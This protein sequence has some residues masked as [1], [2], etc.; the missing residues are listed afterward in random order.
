MSHV[1]VRLLSILFSNFSVHSVSCVRRPYSKQE[2]RH[3]T[4]PPAHI[5]GIYVVVT[6]SVRACNHNGMIKKCCFRVFVLQIPDL[7]DQMLLHWRFYFLV[8]CHTHVGSVEK[9]EAKQI[10]QPVTL[11]LQSSFPGAVITFRCWGLLARAHF[12]FLPA[13]NGGS[14]RHG[15]FRGLITGTR[16]T[17]FWAP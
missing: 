10:S 14:V 2:G 15:F 6:L 9:K 8:P 1:P 4:C 3:G 13:F 17:C 12:T 11:L 5:I 16:S 7:S